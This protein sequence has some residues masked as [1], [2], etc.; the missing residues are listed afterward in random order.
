MGRGLLQ[1]MDGFERAPALVVGRA[2]A[3][4]AAGF[5]VT[6]E[7]HEYSVLVTS[8]GVQTPATH[9]HLLH[10][11]QCCHAGACLSNASTC[12][13]TAPEFMTALPSVSLAIMFFKAH[14]KLQNQW[15]VHVLNV[16]HHRQELLDAMKSANPGV[17][18]SM[19]DLR[20]E[21]MLLGEEPGVRLA[22]L[23]S[24]HS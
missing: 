7:P 19:G 2:T 17:A 18:W 21:Y 12:K 20:E 23:P 10:P 5:V 1:V 16:L 9:E 14:Q 6:P 4:W 13:H 11:A 22:Q 3:W 24:I 8:G 15:P